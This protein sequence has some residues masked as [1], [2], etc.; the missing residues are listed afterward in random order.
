MMVAQLR[1][2]TSREPP[3]R[4][5]QRGLNSDGRL[6]GI[7]CRDDETRAYE[8]RGSLLMTPREVMLEVL[9]LAVHSGRSDIRLCK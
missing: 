8:H 7:Q 4:I 2:L 9:R 6:L 5:E 1:I 3:V